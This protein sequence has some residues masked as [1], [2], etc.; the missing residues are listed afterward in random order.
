MKFES[1]ANRPRRF[2]RERGGGNDVH[3]LTNLC[4]SYASCL[5]VVGTRIHKEPKLST[6]ASTLKKIGPVVR[7]PALYS[8]DEKE[9]KTYLP[10]VVNCCVVNLGVIGVG[11]PSTYYDPF[12]TQIEEKVR[13]KI[14]CSWEWIDTGEFH[15]GVDDLGGDAHCATNTEKQPPQ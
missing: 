7:V 12:I 14:D 11:M 1:E 6:A 9:S 2:G 13:T 4:L 8:P 3:P 5:E 15:F 10:N